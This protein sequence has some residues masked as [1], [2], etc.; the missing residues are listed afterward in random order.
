VPQ[1]LFITCQCRLFLKIEDLETYCPLKWFKYRERP[2][3]LE[4]SRSYLIVYAFYLRLISCSSL[5]LLIWHIYEMIYLK[6][7]YLTFR[8]AKSRFKS[9]SPGVYQILAV[10]LKLPHS[11]FRVIKSINLKLN[12]WTLAFFSF[13]FHIIMCHLFLLYPWSKYCTIRIFVQ[14]KLYEN[15][16]FRPIGEVIDI[17]GFLILVLLNLYMKLKYLEN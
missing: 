4:V 11:K 5:V 8:K 3:R 17:C 16:N 1:K 15:K 9:F 13:Y 6:I 12:S 2:G 10:I 7:S 14:P